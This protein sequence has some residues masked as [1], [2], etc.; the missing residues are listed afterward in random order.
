MVE[1]AIIMA[2]LFLTCSH[3]NKAIEYSA[4]SA[5]STKIFNIAVNT[6]N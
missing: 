3:F 1:A 5:A 2:A 6:N 4:L